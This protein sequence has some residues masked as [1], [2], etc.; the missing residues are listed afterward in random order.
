MLCESHGRNTI[1]DNEQTGDSALEMVSRK[2]SVSVGGVSPR[3]GQLHSRS[4]VQDNSVISGV[5]PRSQGVPADNG[6]A[7]RMLFASQLNVQLQHYVSWRPDPNAMATD[8]MQILWTKGTGY[9][10]PPF[11]LIGR[12]LK[13]VREEKASLILVAPVWRS[14]PWYPA[15]LDLLVDYPRILPEDQ[16]LLMDLSNNPHPLVVAGQLH[17]A[18]WRLSGLVSKQQEFLEKLPD[19]SQQDGAKV[20]REHTKV[21]GKDRMAGVWSNKSIPFLALFRTF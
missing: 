14:Q 3:S 12:C 21:L 9:A 11:C 18:T 13:K 7:G 8:S 4:G 16:Q 15:L 1:P 19:S 10:F 2:E 17:L 20:Q 5:V 6:S